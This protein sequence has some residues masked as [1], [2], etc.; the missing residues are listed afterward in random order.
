MRQGDREIIDP[1]ELERVI[2]SAEVCRLGMVDG[3][4]PYV[5]PMNFG[6]RPG[7][8]YFHSAREG[9]KLEVLRRNPRVCFELETDVRL[10]PGEKACQ[11]TSHF[12]S[13]IGWGK[14]SVI[15]DERGV[16]EGL[17]ALMDH[18]S[19]GRHE[20]DPGPLGLTAVIRLDVERMSGKR[21]KQRP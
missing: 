19:P 12:R 16:E 20:F 21:S 10:V 15:T 9:R 13:V 5:V 8:L 17:Q 18:Y 6:Y 2:L 7:V 11:W 3:D 14:A 4:E 1:E